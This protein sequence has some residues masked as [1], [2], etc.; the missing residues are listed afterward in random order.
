MSDVND[1]RTGGQ[2]HANTWPPNLTGVSQGYDPSDLDTD[3]R[4]APNVTTTG[5]TGAAA[6]TDIDLTANCVNTANDAQSYGEAGKTYAASVPY[7]DAWAQPRH[8][9]TGQFVG[10]K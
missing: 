1:T 5:P 3:S 7:A 9:A 4:P 2:G 10:K 8:P 6:G